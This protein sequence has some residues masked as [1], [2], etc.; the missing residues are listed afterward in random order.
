MSIA[1]TDY[2][3]HIGGRCGTNFDCDPNGAKICIPLIAIR[4]C[5]IDCPNGADEE[6]PL[7]TI[8][9]DSKSRRG[10]G[11]CVKAKERDIQCRDRRW[12]NICMEPRHF[13]C[14]STD[15]C[16]LI[17]WIG[18]GTDD[19]GDGSDEGDLCA[20]G[21]PG[22]NKTDESVMVPSPFTT[23]TQTQRLSE[24]CSESQF[25]CITSHEC[26]SIVHVLDGTEHCNDG[27]DERYCKEMVGSEMCQKSQQCSFNPSVAAFTCGCPFGYK[28]SIN[29]I[30][31]PFLAPS[32]SADCADLQRRYPTADSGEFTLN[33]WSCS[34]PEMCSFMARCEMNLLGGGW[35]IIMQRFNTTLNFNKDLL[36]YEDGFQIDEYN[37]WIG[38]ERMY[39]LTNRPH[40]TNELLLRLRT[41]VDG[42]TILVRY[43]HFIVCERVLDY[44]LNLG[45][46]VYGNGLN[47]VN[48]LAEGHLCAF[49]SNSNDGNNNSKGTI[50][51]Q[52]CF[53]GGGGWWKRRRC[54]SA[55][56]RGVLTATNKAS[57]RYPGL[58]WN[59][60]RLSAVQM[61]IRPR[62]FIPPAKNKPKSVKAAEKL[63]SRHDHK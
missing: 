34:K 31:F 63:S 47:T 40:C 21:F 38:L 5:F 50:S 2:P 8:L 29:G 9:C 3:L 43:S 32:F 36:D 20:F 42:E 37:F 44:R 30:C 54:N 4:D 57:G 18:D 14:V 15:N 48:E 55:I 26:I 53:D 45:S 24:E 35:T 52:N 28:R 16:I 10:C 27:S 51:E 33:D 13:K 25:Q 58:R 12:R 17:Q 56:Q 39:R 59:G 61:L 23:A 7:N 62:G 60:K 6:C 19:C 22:C 11:K 49:V 46:I 1:F 41:A